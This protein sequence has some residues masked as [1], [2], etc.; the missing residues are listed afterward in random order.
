MREDELDRAADLIFGAARAFFRAAEAPLEALG[1]GAAHY[2]ALA[3]IRRG[4]NATVS[5]LLE[6]LAVRKQSLAR[7][8][9]ELEAAGLIKRVASPR[10][11]RARLVLLTEAGETAERLASAAL[12]ERLAQVFRSA[13]AEAVGGARIVLTAL[14]QEGERR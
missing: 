8:L 3:A 10:D 14:A 1:L 6:R 9:N 5:D 13:G 7:V 11:R 12:R 4:Q 2:R